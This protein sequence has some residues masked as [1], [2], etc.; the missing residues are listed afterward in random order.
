MNRD[1]STLDD[2]I[3]AYLDGTAGEADLQAVAEAVGNDPA[4][5]NL[6]ARHTLLRELLEDNYADGSDLLVLSQPPM[7]ITEAGR[8]RRGWLSA[9]AVM[10]ALLALIMFGWGTWLPRTT[11]N[12]VPAGP[13]VAVVAAH[14]PALQWDVA[15]AAVPARG[16]S[17]AAGPVT[18]GE[19]TLALLLSSGV[20]LT[21]DG[22]A[23]F[24]LN[25]DMQVLLAAGHISAVVPEGAE[26]FVIEAPGL[27]VVDLGTEFE[28]TVPPDGRPQVAVRRGAVEA[29]F[30]GSPTS[31]RIGEAERHRFDPKA[32][33]TEPL[34][35][36]A[37][38]LPEP[39]SQ[40]TVD[41]QP[42]AGIGRPTSPAP[43]PG[44]SSSLKGK[45]TTALGGASA[46]TV[47]IGSDAFLA[48]DSPQS[49]ATLNLG[50]PGGTC[51]LQLLPG[52]TLSV[53]NLHVA[54][55]SRLHLA[56]GMLTLTDDRQDA[57]ICGRAGT[58][59]DLVIDS[60]Y[61]IT[62]NVVRLANGQQTDVDMQINGGLVEVRRP[63]V[64]SE[65]GGG[66]L[67]QTGGQ[68]RVANNLFLHSLHA[69]EP[70]RYTIRG[71]TLMG[72][73]SL[74]LGDWQATDAIF[75]V[76]GTEPTIQL[77][78]LAI[79]SDCGV[80]EFLIDATGVSPITVDQAVGLNDQGTLRLLAAAGDR[81]LP[82][83]VVLLRYGNRHG[84]FARVELNGLTGKVVY[85]EK[86]GEIRL[87]QINRGK[88]DD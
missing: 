31:M 42:I 70:V 49:L 57:N 11:N 9:A 69:E 22:P 26:G 39:S 54:G 46:A 78:R 82:Q 1:H 19:G 13:T 83:Q 55:Q 34:G 37:S 15:A 20:E 74:R 7:A 38:R 81:P 60:G 52:G 84:Q 61:L 35:T 12:A 10:A 33:T 53:E 59:L 51:G 66:R 6:L 63:F 75:R 56:G 3:Q 32:G 23:Q 45:A 41:H 44:S 85:D 28:V 5:A 43:W 27:R 4:A 29:S 86:L 71:G 73:G 40:P 21:V 18:I 14:S 65:R 30:V 25:S 16:T 36:V 80:L 72:P 47:S 76:E 64:L 24:D 50:E 8:P 87:E 79:A 17:L 88:A 67:L 48:I 77:G 62:D 68:F 2:Q 58:H